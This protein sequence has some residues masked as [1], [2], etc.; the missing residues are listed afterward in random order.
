MG[1]FVNLGAYYF[2]GIPVSAVLGFWFKLEGKGLW[3]GIL[4]GSFLQTIM[5]A[6]ITIFTNWEKKVPPPLIE[7]SHP[8][9]FGSIV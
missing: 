6:V 7:N 2:V 8:T 3:I 4:V 9:T 1:A 5:L